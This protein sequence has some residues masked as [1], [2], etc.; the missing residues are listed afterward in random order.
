MNF[1]LRDPRHQH[2]QHGHGAANE[3]E[4]DELEW[5]DQ[6]TIRFDS[7]EVHRYQPHALHKLQF[8]N[9]S[10]AKKSRLLGVLYPGVRVIH[11]RHGAG[12]LIEVGK[13]AV[14]KLGGSGLDMAQRRSI[15]RSWLAELSGGL[16]GGTVTRERTGVRAETGVKVKDRTFG[17]LARSLVEYTTEAG[18]MDNAERFLLYLDQQTWRDDNARL[19]AEVLRALRAGM[20]VWLAHEVAGEHGVHDFDQFFSDTVRRDELIDTRVPLER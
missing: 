11:S 4:N 1:Y 13:D 15:G 19:E 10:D 16:V 9:L 18:S 8:E 7:G 17:R 14:L 6:V 3:P 5:D 12:V 2:A 20:Q